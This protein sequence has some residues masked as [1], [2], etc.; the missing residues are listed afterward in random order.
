MLNGPKPRRYLV[1]LL[2]LSLALLFVVFVTQVAT[3]SHATG[4]NEAACS[5]CH[6]AHLGQV[7]QAAFQEL[8]TPLFVTGYV[9]PFL[10]AFHEELFFHD[11]P[12]RAPPSV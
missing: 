1:R 2:G 11:S 6:A 4:Q 3:H 7:P 10:A 12:S 5:V 9:Q 8:R